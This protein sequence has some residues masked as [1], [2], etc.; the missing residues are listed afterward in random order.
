MTV[1]NRSTTTL[2]ALILSMAAAASAA[3]VRVG[4][5]APDFSLRDV[6]ETTHTLSDYRG[7]VVLLGLIGYS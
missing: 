1:W 2:A 7:Q 4:D 3:P 5:V 6:N